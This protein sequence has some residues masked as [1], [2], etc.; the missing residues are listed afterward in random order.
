MDLIASGIG[1]P[2]V[3]GDSDRERS[4]K[5]QVLSCMLT[6]W[7]HLVVHLVPNMLLRGS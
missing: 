3:N 5:R 1:K 6:I 7:T 4:M 2:I